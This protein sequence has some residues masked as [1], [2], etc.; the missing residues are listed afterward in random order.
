[1]KYCK[2]AK[3][4]L[5]FIL[6]LIMINESGYAQKL[7]T[8]HFFSD[9]MVLQR[10]TTVSIWGWGARGRDMG[11]TAD[12]LKDTLKMKTTGDARWFISLPTGK[13]GGPHTITIFSGNDTLQLKNILLGDVWLCS[14]QSNMQ[15]NAG[16]KLQE[17]IDALPNIKNN[18]IRLLQVSNIASEYPQEDIHDEWQVCDS[19]SA[20]TFS[21]IGYFFAK[22]LNS[23]LNV[24][25]GIVNASW[26]GTSAEVWTPEELVFSDWVLAE[27]AK[28]QGKAPSKPNLPGRAWNGM[29]NPLAGMGISGALWY[30]G[31]NNVVSWNT[32]TTLFSKM[33]AG[34]RNRWG[35]QFPF[36]FAQIAPYTYKN[37]D[38]PRAALLREAQNRVAMTSPDVQIVLTSDLVS[39]IKNIHPT[40][41]RE[42][43]DRFAAIALYEK[44]KKSVTYPY[45][46]LYQSNDIKGNQMTIHFANMDGQHL[47]IKG[48]KVS[49][50][51]IAGDDRKFYPADARIDKDKLVVFSSEVQKPVAVRYA[52][53]ETDETKT[54]YSSNGQP[55]SLFRTDNWEQFTK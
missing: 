22:R 34:W 28:L 43:A 24:P 54:L 42:V 18:N 25:I 49:D 14:G 9:N 47:V 40:R 51:Y 36:Y 15:Y 32:Y 41:K 4:G 26:G 31:E 3:N 46:P 23:E 29:I 55:V 35:Y 2:T 52:F 21:A 10:D 33:I 50:L 45:A 16:N 11:L 7:R 6:F 39:D 44:Y 27:N 12:W 17:M 53:S 38:L 5:L 30:Q 48:D 37:K 20:S 13:A 8:P 1:M 19:A